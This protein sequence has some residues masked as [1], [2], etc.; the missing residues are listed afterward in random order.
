MVL[1]SKHLLTSV[2]FT[3]CTTFPGCHWVFFLICSLQTDL[4]VHCAHSCTRLA[5]SDSALLPGFFH[6]VDW[7]WL[8][9]HFGARIQIPRKG[10]G[11]RGGGHIQKRRWM[12]FLLPPS[13][14]KHRSGGSPGPVPPCPAGT[15]QQ[16]HSVARGGSTVIVTAQGEVPGRL[17]TSESSSEAC[18]ARENENRRGGGRVR[19]GV[20]AAALHPLGLSSTVMPAA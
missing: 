11:T 4:H 13:W 2:K 16:G 14:R 12:L 18:A 8:G 3:F 5:Q 1:P 19:L 9:P 6:S 7:S 15:H 20:S 17:S 10:L